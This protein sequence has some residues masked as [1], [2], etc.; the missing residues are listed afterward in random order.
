[1]Y[2]VIPLFICH[3]DVNQDLMELL[4]RWDPDFRQDDRREAGMT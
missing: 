1:M 2:F 3:P 4:V